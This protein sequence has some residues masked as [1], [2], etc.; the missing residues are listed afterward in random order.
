A[1][2]RQ[3]VDPHGI[4][5][6][7]IGNFNLAMKDDDEKRLNKLY[8]TSAY[9]NMAG[10]IQGYQQVAAANAMMGAGDAMREGRAGGSPAAGSDPMLAGAG[11]G[12]G[13]A[14]ANQFNASMQ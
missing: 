10:G 3:H 1:G 7:S 11:L 12:I 2:V 13:M 4:E 14:M 8:E 6:M 9:V 5:V